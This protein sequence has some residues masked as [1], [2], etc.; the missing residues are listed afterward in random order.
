M[1]ISCLVVGDVVKRRCNTIVVAYN[2]NYRY[3]NLPVLLLLL[4][5]LLMITYYSTWSRVQSFTPSYIA[6][7]VTPVFP[8]MPQPPPDTTPIRTYALQPETNPY[9][10]PTTI[11]LSGV[12]YENVFRGLMQLYPSNTLDQRNAMSRTDAYWPYIH[13]GLDPPTELTYGEF[14]FYFFAQLLDRAITL[15]NNSSNDN[16]NNAPGYDRSPQQQQQQK[17]VFCDIGSGTGRLVV[18]AAT[19]HPQLFQLCRGI[20]LLPN[21]HN[22]ATETLQQCRCDNNNE[23][24][25][26]QQLQLQSPSSSSSSHTNNNHLPSSNEFRTHALRSRDSNDHPVSYPMAPIQF[27]CGSFDDPYNIYYGDADIIFI[28][29]SCMGSDLVQNKLVQSLGRQCRIGTIIITTDYMLPLDGYIPPNENDTR[30]PYGHYRLKLLESIDGWCWLTGGASTAYIHQV[31]L[32]LQQTGKIAPI[33]LSM[34]ERA[35]EVVRALES[36][37]LSDYQTFVRN[38]RNNMI[39]NGFPECF[40]PKLPKSE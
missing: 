38:V 2:Y 12:M 14:D 33:E 17:K 9:A 35:L 24:S 10:N 36:G 37:K 4:L 15:S 20:E 16:S 26:K 25:Q 5:L 29:S 40:I 34:Q 6:K 19:L 3:T 30:M 39:F 21:I 8:I 23:V 18:A 7:R 1:K 31:E 13:K 28:F 27:D 11:S 32:S 22:L